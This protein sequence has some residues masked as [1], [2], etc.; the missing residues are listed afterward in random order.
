[1][2]EGARRHGHRHCRQP[3]KK[4]IAEKQGCDHVIDYRAENF[5]DRVKEITGGAGVDVVYDGVGKDTFPGSL[6]CLKPLGTWVSFGNASGVVPPFSIM[7]L[8]QK[9]CLFATRA[10]GGAYLAKRAD[11]EHSANSLFKVLSD[12]T[13]KV[14]I[15]QT[16]ALKD[17]AEAHRVLEGRRTVGATVLLP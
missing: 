1:V 10:A 15:G 12:G 17:A 16:F 5:V 9:G 8:M 6:D 3:R 4:L 14:D 2:G 13:V 11:L 7:L